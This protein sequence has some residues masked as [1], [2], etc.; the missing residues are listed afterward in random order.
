MYPKSR[1]SRWKWVGGVTRRR[2]K[3]FKLNQKSRYQY[4]RG[5][6]PPQNINWNQ[7]PVLIGDFGSEKRIKKEILWWN[8][9][10]GNTI[11]SIYTQKIGNLAFISRKDPLVKKTQ[12]EGM[13][14]Y[15]TKT[16]ARRTDQLLLKKMKQ[17]WTFSVKIQYSVTAESEQ[18]PWSGW[19]IPWKFHEFESWETKIVRICSS[20]GSTTCMMVHKHLK[21]SWSQLIS[22]INQAIK[23][24]IIIL[25]N[26]LLRNV[27]NTLEEMN[28]DF[29]VAWEQWGKFRNLGM[30]R[31]LF[32]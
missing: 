27:T 5:W 23:V 31:N 17:R 16:N 18:K 3:A 7:V 29:Q 25:R 2:W 8:N 21:N 28:L 10:W 9:Y 24:L 14:K 22:L 1:W 30:L 13:W 15:I 32:Y 4:R 19:N 20:P 11:I 12:A 6:L 26:R